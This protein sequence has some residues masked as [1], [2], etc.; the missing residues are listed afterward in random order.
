MR[1]G[2]GTLASSYLKITAYKKDNQTIVVMINPEA[3]AVKTVQLKGLTPKTATSYQTT[4]SANQTKTTLAV[5]DNIVELDIPASSVT[6]VV[7]TN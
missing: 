7:I 6:T 5:S 3:F 1:I 2:M 4:V